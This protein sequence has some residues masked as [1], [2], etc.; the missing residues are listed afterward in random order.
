MPPKKFFNPRSRA[1]CL[2][3][4]NPKYS[5]EALEDKLKGLKALEWAAAQ[6]ERGANGTPHFQ[7]A[8]GVKDAMTGTAVSKYFGG[9]PH[10]EVCSNPLK[11]WEY[12]QKAETREPGTAPIV[13]GMPKPRRNV[14]GD[15]KKRN[16]LLIEK[17]AEQAVRDG[18]IPI[19]HYLKV[20]AN[21]KAF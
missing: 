14:A 13:I 11:A 6:L 9:N 18:D 4:N 21:I 12:C 3:I 19:S 8:F 7:I 1:W 16:A 15:T 20:K 5:L 10:R 2:T 17:G